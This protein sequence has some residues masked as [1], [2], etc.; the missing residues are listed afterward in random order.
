M[1]VHKNA[2]LNFRIRETLAKSHSWVQVEARD[3]W[4]RDPGAVL[5]GDSAARDRKFTFAECRR[6]L[7]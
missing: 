4:R 5:G 7:S 1:D 3:A 6:S 2:R